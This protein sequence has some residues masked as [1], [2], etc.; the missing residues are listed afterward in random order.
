VTAAA[1][2]FHARGRAAVLAGRAQVDRPPSPDSP[3][4]GVSAILRPDDGAA[5]R[6][7]AVTAQ[8]VEVAGPGQWPTGRLG[9]GHLTVRGLEPYREPVN[10]DDAAVERYATA[11]Q[12]TAA[13]AGSPEFALTG[14]VLLPGG[15]LAVAEPADAAAEAL[16][17]LLADALGQDGGFE[18]DEYR[19]G[20][21]WATLVHFAAPPVDPAALVDWVEARRELDLGTFRA[22]SLDLVRY[23][24][25][26]SATSPVV[27]ATA[28]LEP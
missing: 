1:E 20:L 27:L 15:V 7:A 14:L 18:D 19:Q 4:W 23:A 24:Y 8:A 22:R 26:G 2:A 21:W 28:P 9:S 3:R 10:S 12:K 6:L 25:D 17:G 13:T 16:R 11:V 5:E